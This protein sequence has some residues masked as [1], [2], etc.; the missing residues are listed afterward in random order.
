MSVGSEKILEAWNDFQEDDPEISTEMLMSL[1][2]DW[3]GCSHDEMIKAVT[4]DNPNA[5]RTR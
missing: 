2:M 4:I 5:R 3:T 1:T